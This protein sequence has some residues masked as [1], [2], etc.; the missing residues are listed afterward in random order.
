MNCET[1][2]DHISPVERNQMESLVEEL[3][4]LISFLK[5]SEKKY[6]EH[7]EVKDQTA[8]IIDLSYEAE[9]IIEWLRSVAERKRSM[10]HIIYYP[11]Y[12]C[13]I[14]GD[15]IENIKSTKRKLMENYDKKLSGF[16]PEVGMSS[17]IRFSSEGIPPGV[18]EETVVGFDYEAEMIKE[19]LTGVSK[20]LEVI[21][22]VGMAGLGKT[23]L[24]RKVYSDLFIIHHFYI[25]GWTCVSQCYQKRNLLLGILSS[26]VEHEDEICTV[27]D[28]KLGEELYKRLKGQR[29]LIVMDDIWHIEAW[30]DLKRSFPNDNNGSRIMLTSR[31][32][33]VALHVKPDRTLDWW[34]QVAESVTSYI[35]SDTEQCMEAVALSYSHLPTHLKSCFLYFVAFP[36]DH[37]IRASKLISLWIAEGFI[38]QI[39]QKSLED[40]GEEYLM[41]LIGRS[42]VIVTKKR[43][44]GE[45]KACCIHD[46]LR[47]FCL[48]QAEEEN[49][50]ELICENEEVSSRPRA[51]EQF[52]C[53]DISRILDMMQ[54]LVVIFPRPFS[55]SSSS[56]H[57]A[58]KQR[59]LCIH[60]VKR[61]LLCNRY[62]PLDNFP[63]TPDFSS[64]PHIRSFLWF[65]FEQSPSPSL[66]NFMSF[67]FLTFKL[68]RVLDLSAISI[69]IFFYGI[70]RLVLLRYL[71]LRGKH[72]MIPDSISHLHNLETL[73]VSQ[74]MGTTIPP[75]IWK[76]V[77][78]RHLCIGGRNKIRT[79]NN[80]GYPLVLDNM[81]TITQIEPSTSCRS[82]L[83]MTPNLRKLGFCGSFE[84]FKGSFWFPEL[85]FLNQLRTLKLLNR[86]SYRQSF[87]LQRVTFPPNLRRLI[88]SR[89]FLEWKEMSVLGMLLNLEAL[90]LEF[91]A[92]I[93]PCWETRDG[94]FRRLK[95]LR[96][97]YMN[98]EQWNASNSH[99]PR[100]EHLVLHRCEKL[101]KIPSNFGDT[102]TLQTIEVSWCSQSS[103]HSA[104][105]IR[106][107]QNSMGNDWL[108]ITI[109]PP[110]SGSTSMD[111]G[112]T[113]E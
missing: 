86:S 69:P 26:I 5:D 80:D 46:L 68:L 75:S 23:T 44:T 102:S 55:F 35:I 31:I 61:R 11:P 112:M 93:G 110:D 10:A 89:T 36:E 29:Y 45:I 99:F 70:V 83:A 52:F 113:F 72:L 20:Q 14:L 94:E 108:Q 32:A 50:M 1:T 59:R 98:I 30:N 87:D 7:V 73:M 62:C 56:N 6:L 3:E 48:R 91:Q 101:E 25:R 51:H 67:Y 28:E 49:F 85:G 103:A 60:T 34:E 16:V 90:K 63:S 39:G 81:Q 106:E 100:L 104:R 95:F 40:V 107:E 88:L 71:A 58:R 82:V 57:T 27:S 66:D 78:L 111:A 64:T 22:I 38:H 77:K 97:S 54:I 37:E 17:H 84:T 21:S 105:Q 74:G 79:P 12:P 96:L 76:M 2:C 8:Q 65:A 13:G 47:D 53:Y 18:D 109:H 19:R 15:V 41:D 4:F 24:A 9:D 33:D 42:L 43:S 92:C